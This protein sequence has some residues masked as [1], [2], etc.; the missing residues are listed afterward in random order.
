MKPPAEDAVLVA[1]AHLEAGRKRRAF[2]TLSRGARRGAADAA[3]NLGY[4]YDAGIG[5]RG[6]RE[7]A[8]RLV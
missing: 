1:D 6:D 4:C 8:A 2:E 7:R 5:S 3:L